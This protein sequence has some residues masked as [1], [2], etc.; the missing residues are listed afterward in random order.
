MEAEQKRTHKLRVV[1][2]SREN[3]FDMGVIASFA[4]FSVNS[5]A[6]VMIEVSS[7]VRSPPFPA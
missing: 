1:S 7:F 5:S 3:A 2:S 6:P 4:V